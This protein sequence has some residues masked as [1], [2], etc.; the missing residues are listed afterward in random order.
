L[1][2]SGLIAFEKV[3]HDPPP[4]A[5]R[6]ERVCGVGFVVSGRDLTMIEESYVRLYAADFARLAVRAELRPL[7]PDMVPK[8][9][10]EARAHA[11][12]MDAKKGEGHLAALVSRLRDEARRPRTH[13]PAV[14]S[15]AESAEHRHLFLNTIADAL[16]DPDYEIAEDSR[17]TRQRVLL[18]T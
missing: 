18:R 6:P 10:A 15:S 1:I 7:D 11:G 3:A 13:G 4:G 8:R 16:S 9:M 17:T 5:A 14:S 2:R 12:V